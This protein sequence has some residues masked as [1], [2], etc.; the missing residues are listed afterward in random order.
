MIAL[1]GGTAGLVTLRREH[2]VIERIDSATGL[3][4]PE[5]V[6]IG[7]DINSISKEKPDE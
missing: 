2:A 3:V 4:K 1:A 5:A 7:P 6:L